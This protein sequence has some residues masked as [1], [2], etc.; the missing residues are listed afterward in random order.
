MLYDLSPSAP[1]TNPLERVW[2]HLGEDLTRNRRCDLNDE[3]KDDS[4]GTCF[5]PWSG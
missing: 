5:P 2:W 1:E 3:L 4:T